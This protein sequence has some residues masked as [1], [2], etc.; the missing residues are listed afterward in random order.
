MQRVQRQDCAEAEG[1]LYWLDNFLEASRCEGIL[2][3]LEFAFWRPSTVY[4]EGEGG[5]HQYVY[6]RR[7][8]S[9][10]TSEQWFTPPLRRA[11]ALIDRRI[12]RHLPQ[13]PSHR[14]EWQATRYEKGGRFDYHHDSGYFDDDAAGERTH[15]VL[16]YLETPERGGETRFPLLDLSVKSVSGRLLIWSNLDCSGQSDP[17]MLHASMPVLKGRKTILVTWIRQ[18]EGWVATQKRRSQ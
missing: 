2:A 3:E 11:I 4:L 12:G 15:S 9:S 1:R 13:A 10:T 5:N 18:R 7:R 17:D 14:E 8:V 6:S 16:L